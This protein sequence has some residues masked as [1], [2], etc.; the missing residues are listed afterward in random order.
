M[1][2]K[3][4]RNNILVIAGPAC[5][6]SLKKG[7]LDKIREMSGDPSFE[8]CS[9]EDNRFIDGEFLAQ[10]EDN[11]RDKDVYV[12]QPTNPPAEN[13]MYLKQLLKAAAD[14]KATRVTAVV[15]YMGWLRQD[16]KDR[17]RISIV[18]Q[19]AAI[20][21]EAAMASAPERHVMILQPHFPQVQGVFRITSDLL[22]PTDIF[23]KA[24][25]AILNGDMANVVPTGPDVGSLKIATT[26]AKRMNLDY[27]VGDKRRDKNEKTKILNIL[28]PV[29]GKQPIIFDDIIDTGGTFVGTCRKLCEL[30]ALPAYGAITHGIL[31]GGCLEKLDK[32]KQEGVFNKLLITDSVRHE[33]PIPEELVGVVPIGSLIGE[34]IVRNNK[35]QSISEIDGMFNSLKK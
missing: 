18:A 23:I 21:I 25:D 30:G 4:T 32:A 19:Q 28:G 20:E 35:G 13:F 8:F 29:K 5:S 27:A 33:T 7:M 12:V 10:I 3:D 15:P 14:A 6:D 24:F 2:T 22:Y 11:V 9:W 26:Y 31:A 1:K 17:P 16:R 34:A